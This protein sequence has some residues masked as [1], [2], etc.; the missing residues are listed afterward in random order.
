MTINKKLCPFGLKNNPNKSL[1][2]VSYITIHCTGNYNA[3]AGAK[4]HADYQC[5]GSGGSQTSWHY[6]VDAKEIWQ[7]FTD[8]QACWHA[9]DGTSGPGNSTSIGLEIC[10][11]DRAVFGLACQNT[12]W[13]T[14]ELLKR[15]SLGI[16]RVVQHFKWNGKGCPAELRSGAWGVT[17]ER[18]LEM[19]REYLAADERI[20]SWEFIFEPLD[21]FFGEN[22]KF[23]F[24]EP[25]VDFF[26]KHPTQVENKK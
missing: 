15:H 5:N 4:N 12:A 18:F 8:T 1:T 9:G 20:W 25:R 19:V 11:N 22:H 17:W 16:D 26:T 6:S 23:R 24:L 14:A 13:L 7:S 10:V 21:Y 3:T 2:A